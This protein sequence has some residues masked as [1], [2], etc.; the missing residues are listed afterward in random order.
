[1]AGNVAGLL[2]WWHFVIASRQLKPIEIADDEVNN[3]CSI[4]FRLPDIS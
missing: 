2:L 4:E 1:M 3:K